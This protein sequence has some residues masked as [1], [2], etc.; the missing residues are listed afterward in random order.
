MGLSGVNFG[1]CFTRGVSL[2]TWGYVGNL[3]RELAFYKRLSCDVGS[4]SLMTYDGL[5][6]GGYGGDILGDLKV[7]RMGNFE[8]FGSL[9]PYLLIFLHP[10]E[11][12]K[13]DVIKTNQ[14]LGS[15]VAIFLKKKYRK[16]MIARCGY[17]HSFYMYQRF[18]DGIDFDRAVELER[19]AYLAA[20]IGIVTSE[21]CKEWICEKC[22]VLE[23]KIHVVPNYV[24]TDR[25]KPLE[26]VLKRY[27]LCIIANRSKAKNVHALIEAIFLLRVRHGREVK[28]LMIGSCIEDEEVN[29][30]I[31]L[32]GLCVERLGNVGHSDLPRYLNESRV[33]VC[34][35][36]YEG[37]PKGLLEA[38]SCGLAC[39]GS[40]VIGVNSVIEDGK[41][42]LLCGTGS[43]SIAWG[44]KKVLENRFL[45]EEL[46]REARFYVLNH[47]SLDCIYEKEL[48]LLESIL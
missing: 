17:S 18:G 37:N 46:S 30:Y 13:L 47:V 35:S 1:L 48:A 12:L 4:V 15:E 22:G 19:E 20:D 42:G 16:K 25:F 43:D 36:L 27:D 34:P 8:G 26:G 21:E 44:I 40:D 6:G 29:N 10:M 5:F 32:K 28:L 24:E 31:E 3:N 14:I 39:I 38:M 9:L 23:G 45:M 33:Y 41:N 11:I 7:L 2:E